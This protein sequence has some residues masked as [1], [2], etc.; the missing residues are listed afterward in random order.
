M[1]GQQDFIKGW[2]SR[3]YLEYPELKDALKES[4]MS[5]IDELA[6][7]AL[8]Y[9]TTEEGAF[10]MG[11]PTFLNALAAVLGRY[12]KREVDPATL[13]TTS[14]GSMGTDIACRVHANAGDVAVS[15]APTYYLAHQMFR[16]RGLELR[17]VPIEEDGMDVDA[18]EK[19]CI[20]LKGAV[21]IVYTVPV[22]HNPTG[23]T[24]SDA[25]RAQLCHLA[26]VHNFV[27]IADE[28]YGLLNFGATEVLPLHY[29]D[30]PQDPHVI[31]VGTFSKLIGPGVKVGWCQA[32]T[33]LLTPM[34]GIG[35]INSG[36]NP[37]IFS[38]VGLAKFVGDGGLEA[39]I[40]FI[41][42]QIGNKARV[43]ADELRA[44]GLEF[45]QP[46]GGYFIWVKSKGKMTGRSG[47]GMTLDPPDQF[48]NY[49]RLCFAWLSEDQIKQGIQFLAQE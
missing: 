4:Y 34:S 6:G 8:N 22:H 37:V 16:E 41:S 21:K 24:M 43:M 48:E 26:K 1:A 18:L 2:P 33:V 40:D 12:Y 47:K 14:G 38:S 11:H 25:K 7:S 23:V 36:N 44:V 17:E 35:F 28:A 5:A 9:G 20:E 29:H 46:E 32:H 3:E 45:M 27:V 10:M 19:L 30:D 39:H 42:K 13:F 49:M 15:E 31:S